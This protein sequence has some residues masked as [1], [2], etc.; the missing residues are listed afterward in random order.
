MKKSKLRKEVAII[1]GGI[2]G[3]C[4]AYFLIKEGH[5][6]VVI[7][8][9]NISCGASFVNAGYV[10]PSRIIPLAEPG[11]ITQAMKW[12][13][14]SSSPFYV[15]PRLDLNFLRWAYYFN[16]SSNRGSVEKA[17]PVLRETNRKSMDLFLS[18]K[19]S[20]DFDFHFNRSGLLVVFQTKICQKKEIT[21]AERAVQEG[22]KVNVLSTNE[23][24]EIQP[25]FSDRAIGAV[26]YLDDGNITPGLFMNNLKKWLKENGVTFFLNEKVEG[27]HRQKLRIVG[28]KTSKQDIFA[29]E[30]VVAAGSWS[31]AL[32]KS[33]GLYVPIQGGKG[34]SI[35]SRRATGIT[36]PAVLAEGKVAVTPMK[37]STR[38]AG[39]MEFSGNNNFIR[40]KR[41]D[42]IADSV[43]SFYRSF[44][45]SHE[46]KIMAES[47]LRPVSPDGLPYIGRTSEFENLVFATGHAMTGISLGPIT[48][49]LISELISEK[50]LSIDIAPFRPDRF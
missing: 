28:L 45:V 31:S 26:H 19:D 1:G 24:M 2:A 30:F 20:S 42:A 18:M 32:V 37:N 38:F 13:F 39:T 41:V 27:F 40:K 25:A 48:G 15:K 33:L 46:E 6:V 3:L 43:S 22:L 49:K 21:K 17:I 36:L 29:D 44:A 16:K 34:Y 14:N 4:S 9:K 5:D 7:D 47:G 11:V 8:E 23:L 10:L 12:M 35:S 50:K